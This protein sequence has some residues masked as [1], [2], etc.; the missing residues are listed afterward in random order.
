MAY[1]RAAPRR[2]SRSVKPPVEA[3]TLAG[4]HV[5]A[6]RQPAGAAAD[7]GLGASQ[8]LLSIGVEAG[9]GEL[10]GAVAAA[11]HRDLVDVAADRAVVAL[12]EQAV[13]DEREVHADRP[14]RRA[15]VVHG[16]VLVGGVVGLGVDERDEEVVV[17]AAHPLGVLGREEVHLGGERAG[18]GRPLLADARIVVVAAA[19]A[20]RR[21][22][23][24]RDEGEQQGG[25]ER[26]AHDR[27][28]S[29]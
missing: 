24:G 13:G 5:A 27:T 19:G 1:T 17:L 21:G 7:V 11:V 10:G 26:G 22:E 15:V 18:V 8:A 25:A 2:S 12:A 9:A 6:Q 20:A 28:P 14:L 23:R 4:D 3:P 16:D 29:E